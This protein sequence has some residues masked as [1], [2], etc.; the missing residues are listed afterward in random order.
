MKSYFFT[1]ILLLCL[2]CSCEK[3]KATD[4]TDPTY[5]QFSADALAYVQLPINKYFIYKDSASGSTDSVIVTESEVEKLFQPKDTFQGLFGPLYLPAY[6]Y[7]DFSLLLTSYSDTSQKDWFYG[8][9]ESAFPLSGNFQT[10]NSASLSLLEK[11]RSTDNPINYAFLYPLDTT[12]YSPQEKKSIIPSVI[13]EGKNYSNVEM[14]SEPNIIDSTDT[15]YL[16]T[17][18]YWAKGVGIIKREI[19]TSNSIKTYVLVR[20][21]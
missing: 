13:I 11:N 17:T 10:S 2:F 3:D 6:Y 18:H 1:T 20:N 16:R 8:V 9:A 19:K 7:Q 21:G 12:I 4:Q 14:Y 5:I 15:N